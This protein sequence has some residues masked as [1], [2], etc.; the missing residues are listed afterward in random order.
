MLLCLARPEL[1]DAR[2]TWPV[3]AQLEP[4]APTR[5]PS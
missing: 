1:L 4:L 5:R 3:T 2:P